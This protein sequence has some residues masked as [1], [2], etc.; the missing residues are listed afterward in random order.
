MFNFANE[1]LDFGAY[2]FIRQKSLIPSQVSSMNIKRV[3]N[4]N[5]NNAMANRYLNI[6][7]LLRLPPTGI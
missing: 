6:K 1:L 7:L 4:G 2:H 5:D 3:F